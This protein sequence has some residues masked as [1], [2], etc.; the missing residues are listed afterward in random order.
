MRIHPDPV[1]VVHVS[2]LSAAVVS[3]R[4]KHEALVASAR[5]S[6]DHRTDHVQTQFIH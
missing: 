3:Q 4:R 1:E 5:K 6:M 2:A